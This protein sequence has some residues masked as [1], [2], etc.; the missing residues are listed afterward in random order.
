[1]IE[2]KE[3]KTRKQIKQFLDFPNN[4]YKGNPYYIPPL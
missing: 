3:V 1:M 4:L 2:I